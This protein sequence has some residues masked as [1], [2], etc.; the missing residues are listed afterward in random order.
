[1]KK[2]FT[3][4]LGVV[5][6]LIPLVILNRFSDRCSEG[7]RYC[8]Y[9]SPVILIFSSSLIS[10]TIFTWVILKR[11]ILGGKRSIFKKLLVGGLFLLSIAI[12][13][14]LFVNLQH[15]WIASLIDTSTNDAGKEIT[16]NERIVK[17]LKDLIILTTNKKIYE[18]GELIRVSIN[19]LSKEFPPPELSFV[20]VGP[21]RLN[22]YR[23]YP[24]FRGNVAKEMEPVQIFTLPARYKV[25]TISGVN[26][27]QTLSLYQYW[28][29]FKGMKNFDTLFLLPDDY[30]A[31]ASEC[32]LWDSRVP[33][34]DCSFG[35][36]EESE[37]DIG[38]ISA[39]T[40]HFKINE[41]PSCKEKK[42]SIDKTFYDSDN[43]IQLHIRNTGKLDIDFIEIYM[44]KCLLDEKKDYFCSVRVDIFDG[45]VNIG[46]VDRGEIKGIK[47]GEEKVYTLKQREYK[48]RGFIQ[49]LSVRINECYD[50]N[51]ETWS[52]SKILRY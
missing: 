29:E 47:A 43:N 42:I 19:T 7:V 22:I 33:E 49:D 15:F 10:A 12:F 4:I 9:F 31:I 34:P 48:G 39:K 30:Y 52:E 37:G 20:E 28:S 46:E 11:F 2:N 38:S 24:S 16:E 32:G 50:G 51:P 13:L 40:I 6:L 17:K 35:I 1:M 25:G 23:G 36:C 5:I 44:G 3:I 41:P 8:C 27:G 45:T 26:I 14:V 21:C 18:Y